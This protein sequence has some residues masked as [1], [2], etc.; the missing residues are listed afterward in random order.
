MTHRGPFQPLPF[1]DSVISLSPLD[2]GCVMHTLFQEQSVCTP[3][4]FCKLSG[5]HFATTFLSHCDY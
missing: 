1:C 2:A 5:N 3:W 4:V